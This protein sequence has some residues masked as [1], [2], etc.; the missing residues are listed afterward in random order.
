ML[1]WL[2]SYIN[3]H[4]Y[5]V[6][7]CY[8]SN[9][10]NNNYYNNNSFGYVYNYNDQQ[11]YSYRSL[12]RRQRNLLNRQAK[13]NDEYS[14]M[15][16]NQ[17]KTVPQNR[18]ALEEANFKKGLETKIEQGNK[19]YEL[20]VKMG[21]E[22]GKGLGRNAEGILEPLMLEKK[23]DRKGLGAEVTST[24]LI[25]HLS[26]GQR[27]RLRLKL[28]E[29]EEAAQQAQKAKELQKPLALKTVISTQ[30]QVQNSRQVAVVAKQ[31][32]VAP[33]I[34]YTQNSEKQN[35]VKAVATVLPSKTAIAT[36]TT[37]SLSTSKLGK[38]KFSVKE[39][40]TP[41]FLQSIGQTFNSEIE[42]MQ[43]R[44]A[45]EASINLVTDDDFLIVAKIFID[46][47]PNVAD[48]VFEFIRTELVGWIG[49]YQQEGL[50]TPIFHSITNNGSHITIVCD[51]NYAFECLSRCIEDIV[52]MKTMES[53]KVLRLPAITPLIYCFDAKYEGIA[54]DAKLFL[55]QL[56]LHKPKLYTDNW[57]VASQEVCPEGRVTY[58]IF[59][60]DERSALAL[61]F[62]YSRSFC[63][64]MQQVTFRN[65]GIVRETI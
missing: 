43:L 21:Y 5:Y 16:N 44:L 2:V 9:Y 33:T 61:N 29:A 26:R 30:Q 62:H 4:G 47:N 39:P 19:G 11:E 40:C 58:F 56:N 1:N 63:I 7:N 31:A 37:K 42:L 49:V 10:Y 20:L 32:V 54:S 12:S 53:L 50:S 46:N 27:R 45:A 17:N 14:N 13:R 60:V 15:N 3:Y 52:Q 48:H 55:S 57:V 36:T 64:C 6:Y 51:N 59:L 24:T 38:M 25:Q 23:S 35:L 41:E 34:K 8:Y 65:R 28:K 18:K 22:N